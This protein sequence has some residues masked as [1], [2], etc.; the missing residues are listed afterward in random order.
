MVIRDGWFQCT[1]NA[2]IQ[3]PM[4]FN[5]KD[6]FHVGIKKGTILKPDETTAQKDYPVGYV[7]ESDSDLIGILKGQLFLTNCLPFSMYFHFHKQ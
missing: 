4:W 7:N 2:I 6:I 3:Q 1:T 5:A